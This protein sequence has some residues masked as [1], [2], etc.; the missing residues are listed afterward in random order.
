MGR[1][2]TSFYRMCGLLGLTLG[3]LIL[4][5][6][7]GSVAVVEPTTTP[8]P[9]VPTRTPQP[10]T[11]TPTVAATKTAVLSPPPRIMATAALIEASPTPT[12]D[13]PPPELARFGVTGPL[14]YVADAVAA[15]LPVGATLNWRAVA[16]PPVPDGIDYWQMLRLSD[17]GLMPDWS[18]IET[19]VEAQ[20]GAFWLVGNEPDVPWQD[21]ITA[22]RYAEL[23]HEAYTFIKA[24]DP[25]AV[26]GAGGVSMPSPLR[27]AYLDAVLQSYEARYGVA[28][29]V[30]LWSVHAFT[31]REEQDSWG[32]GIP[33]GM[34][35]TGGRLFEIDD[36]GDVDIFI[37]H[38]RDFR[39]W[40]AANGYQDTSLAVTE[41]GIL[42]PTDYGFPDEFVAEY[43]Q[44]AIEFMRT[45]T[46]E[47]GL[48]ADNN[49]LVQ[50][51]FWYSLYD[52]GAYPT[53]DLYDPATRELTP[54]GR[55]Y[56]DYVLSIRIRVP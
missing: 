5:A 9:I 38:V 52:D 22:E 21:G 48:P 27:L 46:D 31:L 34:D 19:I 14:E 2:L 15:G 43:L 35:D 44:Q 30:D 41:F 20:P 51:W 40:M 17:D 8:E 13:I 56:R 28:M 6:C 1:L 47:T 4:L 3:A 42:L 12:I 53:G 16:N 11:V 23:Y 32:I 10:A 54:V 24:L 18:D 26:I 49:R 37:Q 50:A 55:A 45:A 39:S 25:S 33:P 29:P 36:H 7:G